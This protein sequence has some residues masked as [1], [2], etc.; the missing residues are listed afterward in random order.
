MLSNSLKIEILKSELSKFLKNNKENLLDI[1]IFGSFIKGKDKP[2]DVDMLLLFKENKNSDI[3]Y[4]L[5]KILNKLD[6]KADISDLLYFDLFLESF[7][8]REA[9]LSEGFSI[10]AKKYVS[11]GLNYESF[12]LIKY[13]LKDLNKSSKMMFYYGLN[14]RKKDQKGLLAKLGAHKLSDNTILCPIVTS[15]SIKEFFDYWKVD[16][17]MFP[18]LIP[19][20]L[21]YLLKD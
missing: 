9:F 7:V 20:R 4:T 15:E 16:C 13:D 2:K 11:E 1:I 21:S 8:A 19:K 6:F 14:G 5:K 3:S 17:L 12:M 10:S 18:V